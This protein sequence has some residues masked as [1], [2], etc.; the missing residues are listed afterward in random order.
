MLGGAV[1]YLSIG[2]GLIG[3]LHPT[4]MVH[5]QVEA[6]VPIDIQY[7]P[8]ILLRSS[9]VNSK[10][11]PAGFGGRLASSSRV[12]VPRYLR[13]FH[14]RT[15]SIAIG[16]PAVAASNLPPPAVRDYIPTMPYGVNECCGAVMTPFVQNE[17][18]P[19]ARRERFTSRIEPVRP[20]HA[21]H[22]D[23]VPRS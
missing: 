21:E 18:L 5:T 8:A 7:P 19:V 4:T 13:S 15:I 1:N 23:R 12:N 3:S 20:F 22:C 16:P 14:A 2:P 17:S 10:L 6:H 9:S 11:P